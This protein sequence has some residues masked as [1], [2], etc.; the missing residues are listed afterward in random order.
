VR[1]SNV[2]N[3][4]FKCNGCGSFNETIE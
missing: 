4:V 3:L 2:Q 1:T